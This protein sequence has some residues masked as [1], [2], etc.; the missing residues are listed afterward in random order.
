MTG[1]SRWS[2]ASATIITRTDRSATLPLTLTA[3]STV[4]PVRCLRRQWHW[5]LHFGCRSIVRS[6]FRHT[7]SNASA[8]TFENCC[9]C[10]CFCFHSLVTLS[11]YV[12]V[13]Y[14][15]VELFGFSTASVS[16]SVAM[17]AVLAVGLRIIAGFALYAHTTTCCAYGCCR[18]H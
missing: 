5:N 13:C 1:P 6:D 9:C 12:V 16:F 2:T 7:S 15:V 17:L 8:T 14:V 3:S 10:F 18:R 11:V 4:E